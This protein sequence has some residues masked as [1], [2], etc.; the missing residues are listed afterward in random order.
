[1]RL[2]HVLENTPRYKSGI[3]YGKQ[4]IREYSGNNNKITRLEI[5]ID[6]KDFPVMQQKLAAHNLIL[7]KKKCYGEELARRRL[8]IPSNFKFI[9]DHSE[10]NYSAWEQLIP[11]SNPR[12]VNTK[13]YD[14]YGYNVRSRGEMI[15]GNVLKDLGLEAKYEPSLLMKGT[16]KKNPDYSFPVPVIDRCFFV[17]FMGM[18]DDDTYIENNYGKIDEYMRNGILPGRD[19]IL[20]CG[21]KDWIPTQESMKRRIAGFVNDSILNTYKTQK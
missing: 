4:V 5:S 17:E 7:E 9:R 10:F 15:V 21:T 12:E 11:C 20:I 3:H 1:M 8:S 13:L 6:G 16:R 18:T 14:D 2:K 19:L